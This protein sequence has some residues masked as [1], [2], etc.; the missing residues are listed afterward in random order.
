[1]MIKGDIYEKLASILFVVSCFHSFCLRCP[2]TIEPGKN[3]RDEDKEREI[4]QLVADNE[5]VK[6][7]VLNYEEK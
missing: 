4:R 5:H 3:E 1:M 2:F 6:I 7:T